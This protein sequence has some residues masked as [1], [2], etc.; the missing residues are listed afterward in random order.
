MAKRI[1][2]KSYGKALEV[3][4]LEQYEAPE[5][6][7]GEILI[8]LAY[9]NINPSD[10]GMIGG[11][12]KHLRDLPATAGREGVG[13]IET[14]GSDV[15]SK[16]KPGQLVKIPSDTPAWQSHFICDPESLYTIPEGIEAEQA[17]TAFINP[18]TALLLLKDI[19]TLNQ[20]DWVIQN[21]GNSAVGTWVIQIAKALGL[22]TISLV[23]REELIEP[24]KQMGADIVLLDDDEYPKQL[25]ELTKGQKPKLALN[26][27]GGQSVS[28]LIKS[29]ANGGTCVTFGGMVGDPVR[30][31]TRYLIFND[32]HLCGF[33]LDTLLR[34]KPQEY[35]ESL[36]NEVFDFIKSDHIHT[37]IEKVYALEDFSVAIE[38]FSGPR[39]GKIL[40]RP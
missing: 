17:A 3:L 37:P 14:V 9:A 34:T 6:K 10:M 2:H 1:I 38:H 4:E 23:R 15:P 35:I 7:Q 24:L 13:I 12:Y 18:P 40:L 39:F 11:S 26:S 5:P 20:G 28:R 36:Y 25:K 30:F 27:I 16:F 31:P 22:H 29:M 19:V 8:K 32:I 33:H 21:A